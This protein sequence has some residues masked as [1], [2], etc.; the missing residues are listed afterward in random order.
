MYMKNY[1]FSKAQPDSNEELQFFL[2]Y[3]F[4]GIATW[5]RPLSTQALDPSDVEVQ[6]LL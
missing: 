3:E 6:G 1:R 4:H 2:W 5:N